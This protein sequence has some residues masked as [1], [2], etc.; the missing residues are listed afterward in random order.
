M[1]D[2]GQAAV[3]EDWWGELS[4]Q[5]QDDVTAIVELLQEL[6]PHL[7][8]PHSSGVE[9]S[10]HSHRRELRIQS[11]GDPLRVF[12]AFDPTRSAVL[13][14]GGNKTGKDKRFYKTMIPKAD[15]LYDEHLINL[16]SHPKP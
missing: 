2:V 14:I 1:W 3:F 15:A 10:R 16:Q 9:G 11:H 5:E 6:G 7:P 12:Y 4:E 13:L 8:F